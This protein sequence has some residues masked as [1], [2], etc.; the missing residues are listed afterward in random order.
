MPRNCNVCISSHLEEIDNMILDGWEVKEVYRT[1]KGKY[2]NENLPSYDSLCN[3][4]KEH[5]RHDN[6]RQQQI[7]VR[8][9][10]AIEKEIKASIQAVEQLSKNLTM[11]SKMLRLAWEAEGALS[12][13]AA[14]KELSDLIWRTNQTVELLLKYSEKVDKKELSEDDI[15]N[16]LLYCMSGL[17]SDTVNLIMSRWDTYGK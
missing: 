5:V 8:K 14:R 1:L 16:R 10:K 3:H 17:P 11:V 12:N 7:E 4:A 2:P 15:F 6:V 9:K 13:Q